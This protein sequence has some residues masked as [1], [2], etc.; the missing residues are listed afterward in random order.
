MLNLL[1]GRTGRLSKT[2]ASKEA[3][4]YYQIV[5]V[6]RQGAAGQLDAAQGTVGDGLSRGGNST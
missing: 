3:L 5:G 1:V 6:V 4:S 2:V